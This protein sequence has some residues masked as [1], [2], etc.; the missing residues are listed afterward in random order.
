MLPPK[1]RLSATAQVSPATNSSALPRPLPDPSPALRLIL[2]DARGAGSQV[3]GALRTSVILQQMPWHGAGSLVRLAL[4]PSA[5]LR[6]SSLFLRPSKSTAYTIRQESRVPHDDASKPRSF[7]VIR[8]RSNWPPENTSPDCDT[9]CFWILLTDQCD[10]SFSTAYAAHSIS[11]S[12]APIFSPVSFD[13]LHIGR[14][15]FHHQGFSTVLL[16]LLLFYSSFTKF[17]CLFGSVSFLSVNF[18][19]TRVGIFFFFYLFVHF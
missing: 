10:G 8:R 18:Y 17:S 3:N 4:I 11:H 2:G 12:V 14:A 16:G 7:A 9:S 1:S 6:S 13:I 19:Q 5:S 15:V